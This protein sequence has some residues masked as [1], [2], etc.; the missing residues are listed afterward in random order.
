MMALCDLKSVAK[1]EW[2]NVG[3]YLDT[4]WRIGTWS[5]TGL[6]YEHNRQRPM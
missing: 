2:K 3:K 5:G 1:S 6:K 4:K